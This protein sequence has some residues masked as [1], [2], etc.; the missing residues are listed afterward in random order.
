MII[1]VQDTIEKFV[2]VG[3]AAW[4]YMWPGGSQFVQPY[5]TD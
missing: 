1:R 3:M 2:E 4:I 5:S